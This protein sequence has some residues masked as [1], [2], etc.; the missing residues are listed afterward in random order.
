MVLIR[1]AGGGF[2]RGLVAGL[3]AVALAAGPVGA[4]AETI[5]LYNAQHEQGVGMLTAAFT[6]ATGIA[7]QVHSGEG[8]DIA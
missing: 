4:G 8:P 7:V 1:N 5:T 6:K 3:V 2:M